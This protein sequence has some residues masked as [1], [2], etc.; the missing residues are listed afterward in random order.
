LLSGVGYS[1]LV[2]IG[3][4]Y[5]RRDGRY[6]VLDI[7]PRLGGCFRLFVDRNGLDVA[8]AMYLDLTG[9]PVPAVVPWEGRRWVKEDAD[10][11]AL[12]YYR[13]LDGLK[14]RSWLLSVWH[15]DEGATFSLRDPLPFLLSL[16]LLAY[17]TMTRRWSRRL[18]RGHRAVQHWIRSWRLASV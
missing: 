8:R 12:K 16:G 10:L 11:I 4:R 3:Y 14:V 18:R 17:Q 15:A 6:K 13:R 1:G 2:D 7:N 9:E 5:D